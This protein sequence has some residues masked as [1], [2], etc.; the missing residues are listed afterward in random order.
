MN[1][2]MPVMNGQELRRALGAHPDWRRIPVVVLSSAARPD[3]EHT[4]EVEGVL[5]KPVDLERL[6]SVLSAAC[7][8]RFHALLAGGQPQA[9]V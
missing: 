8:K 2:M 1:L 3:Q 7:E 5:S 4:L 9:P 6:L